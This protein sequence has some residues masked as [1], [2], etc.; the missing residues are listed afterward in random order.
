MQRRAAQRFRQ[1]ANVGPASCVPPFEPQLGVSDC[2]SSLELSKCQ[3]ATSCSRGQPAQFMVGR[4]A[5]SPRGVLLARKSRAKQV[6]PGEAVSAR[7][8]YTVIVRRWSCASWSL[9]A[10][11]VNRDARRVRPPDQAYGRFG[12]RCSGLLGVRGRPLS[13]SRPILHRHA[14]FLR[15]RRS[16]G[17]ASLG[18][19]SDTTPCT[20]PAA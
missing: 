16:T 8:R 11:P 5:G 17:L 1:I 19:R 6:I 9:A 2:R 14:A 10:T 7:F 20:S 4:S 18:L 13:S 15:I 3:S 12:L